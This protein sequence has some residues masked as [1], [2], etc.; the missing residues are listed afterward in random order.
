MFRS[1]VLWVT[2]SGRDHRVANVWANDAWKKDDLVP[3]PDVDFQTRLCYG[4]RGPLYGKV[5]RVPHLHNAPIFISHE[6][7]EGEDVSGVGVHL[8][9]I[10][11]KKFGF[12]ADFS[13]RNTVVE[14]LPN[15][16]AVG[17]AVEV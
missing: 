2:C 3:M 5:L 7:E 1:T 13:F 9:G 10:L 14:E 12:R 4:P 11:E 16:T 17:I 6:G 8:V 15:G